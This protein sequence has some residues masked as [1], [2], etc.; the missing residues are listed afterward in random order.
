MASLVQQGDDGM[1]DFMEKLKKEKYSNAFSEKNWEE[2]R[3]NVN[4]I[5]TQTADSTLIC[6]C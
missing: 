5:S 3:R 2:V 1:D 6:S 4:R